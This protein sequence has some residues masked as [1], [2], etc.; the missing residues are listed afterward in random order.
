MA[1][2][3]VTFNLDKQRVVVNR[4]SNQ[5]LEMKSAGNKIGPEIAVLRENWKTQ[6]SEETIRRLQEFLEVDFDE[7]IKI[8]NSTTESLNRVYN[9]TK[10][11]NEIR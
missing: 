4:L 5:V 8:F 10:G 7:F 11:M 1:G 3:R 6:G 9:L 2:E